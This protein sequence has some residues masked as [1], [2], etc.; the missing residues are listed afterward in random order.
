MNQASVKSAYIRMSVCISSW[1]QLHMQMNALKCS[2]GNK[3]WLAM[4]W[5]NTVTGRK[6]GAH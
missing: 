1:Q 2:I 4:C 5:F 6:F 3:E